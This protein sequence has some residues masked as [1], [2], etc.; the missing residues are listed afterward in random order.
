MRAKKDCRFQ[1]G[2]A[3]A[4]ANLI[5]LDREVNASTRDLFHSG[6][7]EYN[8][9]KLRRWGIDEQDINLFKKYRKE[10]I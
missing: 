5:T 8:L 2:Y 9:I 7:G 4:V 10:L 6:L 3:C 1:Q